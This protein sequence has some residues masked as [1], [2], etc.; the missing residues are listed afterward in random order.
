[1]EPES[2]KMTAAKFWVGLVGAIITSVLQIIPDGT[3]K[4][5]L[6]ILSVA[7]TAVLVYRVP[8]QIKE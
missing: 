4:A 1:M 7:I 5:V 3:V 2:P 6:T 8:N